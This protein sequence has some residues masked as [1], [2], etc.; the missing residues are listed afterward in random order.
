MFLTSVII[1]FSYSLMI[2]NTDVWLE[3][4]SP[5]H[6][7]TARLRIGVLYPCNQSKI[8]HLTPDCA[9]NNGT[10]MNCK[11]IDPWVSNKCL[12]NYINNKTGKMS[13]ILCNV[14]RAYVNG[15]YKAEVL[16]LRTL[17]PV[18]SEIGGFT[19]WNLKIKVLMPKLQ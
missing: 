10:W 19:K 2:N 13:H 12:W 8:L 16:Q 1:K 15:L 18:T 5:R 9:H 14:P 17:L 3:I 11:P 6:R 7:N 4:Q